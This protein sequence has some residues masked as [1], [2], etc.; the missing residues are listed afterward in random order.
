MHSEHHAQC[1]SWFGGFTGVVVSVACSSARLIF[2]LPYMIPRFAVG[3]SPA[4]DQSSRSARDDEHSCTGHH[5][6]TAGELLRDLVFVYPIE[7]LVLLVGN[8]T[9]ITILYHVCFNLHD[10]VSSIRALA[11]NR[12][13]GVRT[14]RGTPV[15]ILRVPA[16]F[17]M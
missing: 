10:A 2:S 11:G 15:E 4:A 16:L 1:I 3:P 7:G 13:P 9:D 5:P 14:P 8:D 6:D 17:D 12:T